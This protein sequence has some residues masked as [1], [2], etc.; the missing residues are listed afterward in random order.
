MKFD[1]R[2]IL[3]PNLLPRAILFPLAIILCVF[4]I[5]VVTIFASIHT[6]DIADRDKVIRVKTIGN[7]VSDALNEGKITLNEGDE[8]VPSS[9]ALLSGTNKI[10]IKRAKSIEIFD[11]GQHLVLKTAKDTLGEVFKDKNIVL[12]D[13]DFADTDLAAPVNDGMKVAITRFLQKEEA[14]NEKVP[15]KTQKVLSPDL[16]DGVVRVRQQGSEGIVERR[17]NVVYKNG[18]EVSRDLIEE[19]TVQNPVDSVVEYGMRFYAKTSRGEIFRYKKV[20]TVSASA[21]DNGYS[22]CGKSPGDSGYGRTATGMS[23]KVGVVAVDPNV[24]PLYSR[25][26]IEAPNGSWSYGYCVAGDTGGSIKG[27]TVDLFF[28]SPSEARQFGRRSAKVYVL[29]DE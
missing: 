16:N 5:S 12:N 7:R 24:I 15:F 22:S 19:R 8:V 3:K 21:Y 25:L 28:D 17:Y 13:K 2:K 11:N 20:I 27:S 26:Y 9:T 18:V 10:T 4:A 14:V 29:D 1:F 23:A 6:V